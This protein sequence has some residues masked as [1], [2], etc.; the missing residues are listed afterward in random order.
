VKI[1][2]KKTI[3]AIGIA[4]IFISLTLI[5]AGASPKID[6]S[7]E[8]EQEQS[9]GHRTNSWIFAYITGKLEVQEIISAEKVFNNLYHN[10]KITGYAPATG[11]EF[12]DFGVGRQLIGFKTFDRE[13]ITLTVKYLFRSP[14]FN[15]G[16]TADFGDFLSIP[17][18]VGKAI[19]FDI[20][21]EIIE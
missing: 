17:N 20:Q 7:I 6:S 13:H 2:M 18:F 10:V 5:P 19:G 3:L 14:E 21:V 9:L 11:M 1:E 15:E 16:E 4:I 8:D 12:E